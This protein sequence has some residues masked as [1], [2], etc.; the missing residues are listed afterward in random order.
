MKSIKLTFL[1]LIGFVSIS[2]AQQKTTQKV[3]IQTPSVQCEMCKDR[4][5]KYMSREPGIVS[6]KVDYKKKTT[7]VSFLTDRN[8]I[9][10]VKTAIANVGYDADD[11]T[12]EEG[13]YLK[14]P[15]CCKKPVEKS[16]TPSQLP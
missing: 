9:E 12:A 6:V 1:A 7:T 4:I 13:S 2:M 3:V 10:Q 8:D 15:K 16:A 14:L 11:V 5:E